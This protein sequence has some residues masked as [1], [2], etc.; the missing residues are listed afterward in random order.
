MLTLHRTTRIAICCSAA[1]LTACAKKDNA[2]IDT[3][4]SSSASTTTSTA[5]TA[6]PAPTPVNLADFAGKWDVR[7]VPVTGDTTPTTY[8]LTATS[9]TSGWSLKF[10][11]RA[12]VPATITVAGDSIEIDAGPYSSVRRKGVQVTTTGGLRVQNGN[13]VGTTTAHYKVKT[14]DSVLVLN[15]T[16]TRAK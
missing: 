13:L 4:A 8:V 15:S 7:S 14:A 12:A 5:V 16:G 2:A 9:T 3:T 11:G 6:A 10:P 1:V